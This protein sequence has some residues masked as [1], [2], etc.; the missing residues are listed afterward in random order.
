MMKRTIGKWVV[1]GVSVV[2]MGGTVLLYTMN[3]SADAGQE[4]GPGA[5][6][7]KVAKKPFALPEK[8]ETSA[9]EE[10]TIAETAA[11]RPIEIEHGAQVTKEDMMKYKWIVVD[12]HSEAGEEGFASTTFATLHTFTETERK[13]ITIDRQTGETLENIK[14]A[15]T[16]SI[17]TLIGDIFHEEF[18]LTN[19]TLQATYQ[20]SWQ[21]SRI[22][23]NPYDEY[24]HKEE[25]QSML[26]P[27]EIVK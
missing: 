20:L 7:N 13:M 22:L 6:L 1:L 17:Y 19:Q 3:N 11:V 12:M 16:G 18:Q 14:G 27:V 2:L 10:P 23:F 4:S 9:V 24:D 26:Q 25:R 15:D 21:G 8:A 5:K